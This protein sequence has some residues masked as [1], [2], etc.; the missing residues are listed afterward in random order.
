MFVH[1]SLLNKKKLLKMKKNLQFDENMEN[2][3]KI[4]IIVNLK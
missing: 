2:E 3:S 4:N 1:L